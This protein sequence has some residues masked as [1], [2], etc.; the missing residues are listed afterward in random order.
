M[1]SR[2]RDDFIGMANFNIWHI[3]L[4]RKDA[5]AIFPQGVAWSSDRKKGILPF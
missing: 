3:T 5:K 2:A 1:E 4:K